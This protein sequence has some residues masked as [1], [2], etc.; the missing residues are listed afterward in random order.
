MERHRSWFGVRFGFLLYDLTSTF[1]EGQAVENA[2]AAR[3]FSEDSRSDCLQVC[4]RP[5]V[6]QE[7]FLRAYEVLLTN[8]ADIVT[9][10]GMIE[11]M[12]GK[13]SQAE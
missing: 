1:F 8:R 10:E 2:S 3:A 5:V 7:D 13:C 11:I 9:V 6:T 4:I 12:V